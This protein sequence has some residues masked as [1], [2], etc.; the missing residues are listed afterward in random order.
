M[1]AKK[2]RIPGKIAEEI[3]IQIVTGKLKPGTTLADEI[4]ASDRRR[5]SRSAY[6]EAIRVLVAKGLVQSRPKSGTRVSDPEVWHL[7]DPD[8]LSW[9]FAS[10]PPLEL[11]TALF[12][13][14]RMIEPQIVALAAERRTLKQLNEMGHALEVMARETLH[15]QEGRLADEAFHAKLIEACGNPFLTSLSGSVT[16]TIS[17][18]TTFKYRAEGLK[19]DSMPEHLKVY[20]AVAARDGAAGRAAMEELIDLALGDTKH[21]LSPSRAKK[22]IAKAAEKGRRKV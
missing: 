7:M 16:A 12:E 14:R 17:W 6:R 19:R 3:G 2:Q 5:V 21:S 20:E 8:V 10:E 4:S 15:T 22:S 1:T 11:L 9:M 13:L 18:S